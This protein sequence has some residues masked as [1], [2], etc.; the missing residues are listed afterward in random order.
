[1]KHIKLYEN[2]LNEDGYGRDF[3]VKEKDGKVYRYFFKIEGEEESLGFILG[4]G[5]LSRDITIESAENSYAVL[6]IEP[7]SVNAM[8]DYLVKESDFKSREDE[9]FVLTDSEFMR[10]YKIVGEAIKDYLE[11]NP[12]VTSIYD[13]MPLNI[14]MDFDEYKTRVKSLMGS[15]SYDKWSLQESSADRTLLYSRRDHD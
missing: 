1:M 7:I 11:N 3:F 2:F 6:S 8:D 9:V 12:K 5:K 13:E 14:D 15:W 10:T 4:I